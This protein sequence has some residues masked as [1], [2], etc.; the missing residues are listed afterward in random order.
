ML[1]L[2]SKR[3]SSQ[4]SWPLLR[5]YIWM[6]VSVGLKIRAGLHMSQ[7]LFTF[8]NRFILHL[9]PLQSHWELPLFVRN[10]C[11]FLKLS[12]HLNIIALLLRCFHPSNSI[13]LQFSLSLSLSFLSFNRSAHAHKFDLVLIPMS[14]DQ[15]LICILL[16][17]YFYLKKNNFHFLDW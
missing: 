17:F 9:L 14:Y 10:F 11:N 4:E 6:K 16:C 2:S 7:T 8:Q 5:K 3:T 1:D 13:S 12:F 15:I